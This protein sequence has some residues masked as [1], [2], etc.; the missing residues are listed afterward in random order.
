M[1]QASGTF[2]KEVRMWLR[3]RTIDEIY[4]GIFTQ[5][6][7]SQSGLALYFKMTSGGPEIANYASLGEA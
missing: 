5:V 4:S 3:P 6:Q 1:G 2:F 7:A